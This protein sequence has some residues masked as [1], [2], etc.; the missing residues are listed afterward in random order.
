MASASGYFV[1]TSEGVMLSYFI[2]E[3]ILDLKMQ[4]IKGNVETEVLLEGGSRIK[5]NLN[6]KYSKNKSNYKMPEI[7]N[8]KKLVDQSPI[9]G[10]LKKK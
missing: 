7:E 10:S 4:H 5:F 3:L 2:Q 9:F 1:K 6:I 8:M